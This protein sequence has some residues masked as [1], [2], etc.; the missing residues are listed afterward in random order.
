MSFR[1]GWVKLSRRGELSARGRK[2][3]QSRCAAE[4]PRAVTLR[5]AAALALVGWYLMAPPEIGSKTGLP[6][7]STNVLAQSEA[8]PPPQPEKSQE[9]M[10]ADEVVHTHGLDLVKVPGVWGVESHRDSSGRW[11]IV[12][13]VEKI[14]PEVRDEIPKTLNGFPVFIT[15]GPRPIL[16]LAH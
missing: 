9:E 15:V 12:V 2:V 5:H 16:G 10:D 4:R 8:E 11:C 1:H 13:M 3:W 6:T 14:T 7:G